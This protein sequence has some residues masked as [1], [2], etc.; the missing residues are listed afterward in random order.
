MAASA[1]PAAS[2]V[3]ASQTGAI[4]VHKFEQPSTPTGLPANGTVQD[5]TGLTPIPGVTYSVEQVDPATYDLTTNAGWSALK[6]LTPASAS[7]A[8]KGYTTSITTDGA[9][10]ATAGTLPL[11]VYLLTETGYPA[12]VTPAAPFL[13]TVP[14]T[15]PDALNS[16]MY[17]VN[18]YPKNSKIGGGDKTVAD[19][20]ATRL[21]D[22]VAWTILGDIPMSET[23]DGYRIVDPLDSRLTYQNTQVSLDNGVALTEGTDY[24][25]TASGTP[26]TVTVDFLPAGLAK[27]ADNNTAHVKVVISTLVNEAGDIPNQAIIYPNA[28]SFDIQPGEPGGPVVTPTPETKFGNVTIEK[29][30]STDASVKLAGATFKVYT[31]QSDA[32]ADTNA[33]VI[34]GQSSWTTDASGLLTISGLRQSGWVDGHAVNPGD[35][36]FQY[37]WV[38]EV[39]APSGY[40]LLAQPVRVTV[41]GVDTAIDFTV[42][43]SPSNGG[44]QLPFTGSVL[45]AGVFYGA[46]ALILVGVMAIVIRARRKDSAEA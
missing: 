17:T 7:Q 42:E 40:E 26:T 14:M 1:A 31:S 44:F 45:S 30:S 28:P 43:D 12:G 6:A 41:G 20:S 13:I 46:G 27:L 22:L 18:V 10:T 9:G 25:L 33:V 4:I 37:Y 24:T 11:G 36:G 39:Q 16:W 19:S 32:V 2:T 5:T 29:V 21:G 35:T 8:T 38:A 23:I 15:D 34:N 3:D